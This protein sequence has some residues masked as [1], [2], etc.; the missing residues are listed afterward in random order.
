MSIV[1]PE[2]REH[3][4]FHGGLHCESTENRRRPRRLGLIPPL[5][6]P[7]APGVFSMAST[8]RTTT[9]LNGAGFGDVRTEEVPV[10]FGL[11][12]VDEYLSLIADTAG[13]VALTRRQLSDTEHAA[14]KADVEEAFAGFTTTF[15]YDLPG[16]ALCAVAS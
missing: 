12:D 11:T 1:S 3:R 7:P 4:S 10:H 2:C 15:G 8:A 16:V 13:P 14:V 6:P 5:E 9:L